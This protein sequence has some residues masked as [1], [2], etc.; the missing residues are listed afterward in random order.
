MIR[1]LVRL[2]I[3]GALVAC[4]PPESDSDNWAVDGHG[5]SEQHFSP[6]TQIT[7]GNVGTLGLAW[8]LD[9]PSPMGL[10]AE[11]I[12]VDGV[13]YVTTS[14]SRV[15]A[16]DA[17][18]GTVRWQFDPHIRLGEST[19]NSYAA[20]VNRGVAVWD[21]AVFVGT[22]DCRLVAIDATS[23]RER[24]QSPIC[25]PAQTGTTGAPHV[26]QG[27]VVIGYNGSDDK[28]RG[29]IAAFDAHTGKEVWRF[30]T[31]PADPA[32]GAQSTALA[33]AAKTWPGR[34]WSTVGGGDVWD[35]VTYDS[36][37]GLLLFGTAGAGGGEGTNPGPIPDGDKLFS[38]CIVAV[39]PTT[40]AYVWHVQTGAQDITSLLGM[41]P[42]NMHIVVAD[43]VID[44]QPRHVA[45]TVPKSGIFYVI[46]ATTGALISA[47][48]IVDVP[49]GRFVDA[50][51][52]RVIGTPP[53]SGHQW[54]V[55]NWW[56]MSYSPRT[57]LVYVPIT[58]RRA[59]ADSAFEGRLIAWDPVRGV[60]RWSVEHPLG[61]NSSVLST[62]GN[63]VFQG[64]GTG[65]FD[66]FAA[67]DGRRLWSV[68]TG[69][70]I[71]ATPVSFSIHGEQYIVVPVGWGSASRL[72]GPAS[73]MATP[74]SKRG[75]SRVLAFTLGATMPFPTPLDVVPAVPAPPRQPFTAAMVH[76]GAQL[77]ET[78]LCSGCHS[79][80][81]DGSGA[82]TVDGAIPDLRYAPPDVH[83]DWRAIVLTGT[84]RAAG[85]LAFGVDQHFPEVAKLSPREAAAIHAYV[86]DA[87]WKA[88]DDQQRRLAEARKRD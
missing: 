37:T 68:Q 52:G 4:V 86:I 5:A 73:A 6:L 81:L 26:A 3:L 78:H 64:Q 48:P 57:G 18:T 7:D 72:F 12:V 54:T 17:R 36:T 10:A 53:P 42:E 27:N 63:L 84:H 87:A 20:R 34:G 65:E 46:D 61:V 25:D 33:M 40:G 30:W 38:D 11:P 8:S 39:N 35:P 83:R 70:A 24:W 71:D 45:M 62:A 28:V 47:R 9:L 19:Q 51:T 69:S 75:P 74:E 80:G 58:D 77:Y 31:V 1:D 59:G 55:H 66:A 2:G 22:G 56:H 21:G 16:I 32:R 43:L 49:W 41:F 88:Y 50:H 29:S 82:W 23:G 14:L 76:E 79:P 13:M 44:G 60:A 85:M 15:Y 67:S